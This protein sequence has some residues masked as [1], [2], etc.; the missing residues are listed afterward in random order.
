M[1]MSMPPIRGNY[2]EIAI[3]PLALTD[4][5]VMYPADSALLLPTPLLLTDRVPECYRHSLRGI[6]TTPMMRTFPRALSKFRDI[7]NERGQRLRTFPFE[8]LKRLSDA[9]IEHLTVESRPATISTIVEPLPNGGVRVVI[10]G[11][12]KAKLF[13]Q[14]VALDGFYKH[15]DE[16][17]AAMHNEEFYEFD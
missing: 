4:R 10:Q 9:P 17:A 15:A 5:I 14:N 11:F 8:E 3:P 7:V 6:L 12:M 1:T 2:R 13:G 16:T